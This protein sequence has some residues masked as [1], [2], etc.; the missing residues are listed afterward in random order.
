M[1]KLP[2]QFGKSWDEFD[3]TWCQRTALGHSEK[4]IGDSL[5]A[6]VKLW[7]EK[8]QELV[9]S[10]VRGAGVIAPEIDI[11]LLLANCESVDGF[12]PVFERLKQ[13]ERSAYSEI[14]VVSS[15]RDLGYA[16]SF[17]APL[18][19][20]NLDARCDVEPQSVYLE[21]VTPERSD[22]SVESQRQVALL[23]ERIGRSLQDC[24][25]EIEI[26]DT[27]DED[28]IRGIVEVAMRATA[29]EWIRIEGF[30]SVRKSAS[31]EVAPRAFDGSGA[32]VIVAGT[33][34]VQPGPVS[35]LV[36]W[37]DDDSRAKR[38]FN[39]EYHHFSESVPNI[40]VVNACAVGGVEDWAKLMARLFQPSQNRKVGA[41]ALFE[42]GVVGPPEAIRRRWSV[43]RNRH[44]H[45]PV[46]ESLLKGLES[47]TDPMW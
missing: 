12:K 39:A 17:S 6:L 1:A 29:S 44:A 33:R 19:G 3:E 21:V 11:G 34:V 16:V 38:T 4:D 8:V 36:R 25:I 30:A 40:L 35:V 14:V 7:P 22:A 10:S 45:L 42:Q 37:N 26:T 32:D 46:P 9:S 31:G 15:L 13:G 20:K 5:S 28:R 2:D 18:D 24:R 47:L 27:L 43:L 41:I 23:N